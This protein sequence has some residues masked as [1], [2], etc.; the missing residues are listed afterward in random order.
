VSA[1]GAIP[2]VVGNWKM[3]GMIASLAE[4]GR[5]ARGVADLPVAA[6]LALPATL[7]ALAGRRGGALAIGGQ[8]VHAEPCGPRTGG[9]SAPML[10]DAGA[11]FTLVGH[12]ETRRPNGDDDDDR[13]AA[14][15]AAARAAGLAV[16]LCVGETAA[17]RADGRAAEVVTDQ[18]HRALPRH[19]DGASLAIAYE[20]RWA[21]GSGVTPALD[22]IA[23]MHE[24]IGA[25]AAPRVPPGGAPVKR[26]YGGSVTRDNARDI[27]S[28]AGVDGLLVGNASLTAERF[29][30]IATALC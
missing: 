7:L 1:D 28:I 15:L 20:P 19:I 16:I 12:S 5:I 17:H 22:E 30:P 24:I 9:I 26:L 25:A 18:L 3:N 2:R 6:G 11:Q 8:D 27:V 29:L 21:I 13:V 10:R 4:I 14:K 23:A